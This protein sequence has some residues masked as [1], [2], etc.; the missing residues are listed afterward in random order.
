MYTYGL[1]MVDNGRSM[2]FI[3]RFIK[4]KKTTAK[5]EHQEKIWGLRPF[6]VRESASKN[7]WSHVASHWYVAGF[8]GMLRLSHG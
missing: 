5:G 3:Y 4:K 8:L 7:T 2:L 6:Q 1:S